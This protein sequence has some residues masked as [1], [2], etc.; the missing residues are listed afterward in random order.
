MVRMMN[1]ENFVVKTTEFINCDIKESKHIAFTVTPNYVQYAGVVMTTAILNGSGSFSFHIFS[2]K[3]YE[4]D[5]KNIQKTSEKF[6]CNIFLHYVNV[7]YFKFCND[8]GEFSYASYYRLVVPEYLIKYTNKVFYT[9]VDVC[10]LRDISVLWEIDMANKCACVV[11]IQGERHKNEGKR[12]GVEK[13]FVSGGFLI[14]T[15]NWHNNNITQKCF[16][17]AID[18]KKKFVYPDMDI[19]NKVLENKVIFIDDKYQYQ[20]SIAHSIDN[21]GLPTKVTIPE[22]TVIFHYTG[23]IKP[24]HKLAENFEVAKPFIGGGKTV[25]LGE[26]RYNLSRKL[27]TIS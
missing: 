3:F 23:S 4:N 11:K 17:L 15:L 10:F 8:P 24:W 5:I 20:Y 19:L 27:Q 6:N 1:L 12:I 22:D 14:N 2:D 21:E 7:E 25:S 9:D 18:K 13:Y 26:S 16:D